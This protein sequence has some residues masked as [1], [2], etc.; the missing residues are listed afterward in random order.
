[1]PLPVVIGAIGSEIVSTLAWVGA[2][3]IFVDYIQP[4]FTDSVE[5]MALGDLSDNDQTLNNNLL[6]DVVKTN[7]ALLQY[8]EVREDIYTPL[9][10]DST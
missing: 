3:T 1:M 9:N 8:H 5:D 2:G 7:K 10:I 6:E 4:Y